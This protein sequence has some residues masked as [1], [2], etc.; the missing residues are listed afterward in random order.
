MLGRFQIPMIDIHRDGDH[1]LLII[2][3]VLEKEFK[4]YV[5]NTTWEYTQVGETPQDYVAYKLWGKRTCDELEERVAKKNPWFAFDTSDE[6][7]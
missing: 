1:I 6:Y 2:H 7:P 5:R 4:R 3:I